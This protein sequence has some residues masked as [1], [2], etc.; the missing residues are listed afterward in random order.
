MNG[1]RPLSGYSVTDSA[2]TRPPRSAVA[3][4]SSG[5]SAVTVTS[6]VTAPISSLKS[7]VVAWATVSA[8][9]DRTA[10]LNPSAEAVTE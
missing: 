10:G 1:L 3:C 5:A 6:C 9:P 7:S 2:S 8:S 4:S